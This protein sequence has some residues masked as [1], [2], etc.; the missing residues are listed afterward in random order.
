MVSKDFNNFDKEK[1]K[2]FRIPGYVTSLYKKAYMDRRYF[3]H[4][5][6]DFFAYLSTFGNYGRLSRALLEEIDTGDSVLKVGNSYGSLIK[7]IAEKVGE[8]GFVEIIDILP[9]QANNARLKLTPWPFFKATNADAEYFKGNKYDV[10][11]CYFLL[12][13]L[14]DEK[15]SRV[16]SNLLTL[17]TPHGKIVF[18]DYYRPHRFNYLRYFLIWLNR[19]IEPFAE[20]LMNKEIRDFIKEDTRHIWR[21]KSY[22][23]GLYQKTVVKFKKGE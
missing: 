20:S 11:I 8:D 19:L 9:V 22:F 4:F 7:Q 3:N 6:S 2:L 10:I 15:K 23:G 5:D 13:E 21:V 14:P 18:I 12:H 17:L 16:I 1:G